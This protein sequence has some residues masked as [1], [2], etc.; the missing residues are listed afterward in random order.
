MQIVFTFDILYLLLIFSSL[1]I[2]LMDRIDGDFSL[3]I[4]YIG[5]VHDRSHLEEHSYEAYHLPIL[6]TEGT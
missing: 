5:V 4:D 6:F 3:E 2:M 1:M